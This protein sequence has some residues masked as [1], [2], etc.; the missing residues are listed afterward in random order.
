MRLTEIDNIKNF[1]R[2]LFI[3][4]LFDELEIRQAVIRTKS[5]LSIE[6]RINR[7]YLSSDEQE[8]SASEYIKWK[9]IKPLAANLIKGGRPPL[10]IKLVFSVAPEKAEKI[11]PEAKALF[12][13]I[14]YADKKLS[15]TTGLALK[16]FSIDKK[17]EILWDE[18]I[19]GFLKKNEL[20]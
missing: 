18:Y 2:S 20:L 16:T 5:T 1:M 8:I 12:L 19:E 17:Y 14:L 4:D 13:N 7:D 9:E 15:C 3:S 10:G 6:G 11:L